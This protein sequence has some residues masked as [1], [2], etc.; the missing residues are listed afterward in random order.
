MGILSSKYCFRIHGSDWR[1][2]VGGTLKGLSYKVKVDDQL[3][4]DERPDQTSHDIITPQTFHVNHQGRTYTLKVGPVSSLDCTVHV[5]F[6]DEI[7]YRH[8]DLEFV[9]LHRT[10]RAFNK[11]D[12]GTAWLEKLGTKDKRSFWKVFLE[13]CIIGTAAGILYAG[14]SITSRETGG[15]D[16]E[17]FGLWPVIII[18]ILIT[19]A[20]PQKLQFIK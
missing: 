13:T 20:W 9:K 18:G 10:E 1:V 16:F 17:N 7:I 19:F 4:L 12:E 2:R 6:E 5:Y 14:I 11:M 3:L 8:K 15:P